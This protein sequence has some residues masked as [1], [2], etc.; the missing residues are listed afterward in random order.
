MALESTA[1]A[2]VAAVVVLLMLLLSLAQ[3]PHL[4]RANWQSMM[5]AAHLQID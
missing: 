4:N 1:A 2:A 3:I 5:V